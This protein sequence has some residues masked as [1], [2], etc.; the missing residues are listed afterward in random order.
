MS[1]LFVDELRKQLASLTRL[2]V[3][4]RRLHGSGVAVHCRSP[5]AVELVDRRGLA[6]RKR[7][8]REVGEAVDLVGERQALIV[9]NPSPALTL[10]VNDVHHHRTFLKSFSHATPVER[11]GQ[12]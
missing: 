9:I 2:D 6:S 7:C 11:S 4:H 3:T 5:T 12:E 8:L 10:R 1:I